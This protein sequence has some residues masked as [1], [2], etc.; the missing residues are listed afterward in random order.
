MK[1]LNKA[2]VRLQGIITNNVADIFFATLSLPML[3][4]RSRFG[5]R[6]SSITA[7]YAVCCY[8]TIDYDTTTFSDIQEAS[9]MKRVTCKF[10]VT[11]WLNISF[12]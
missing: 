6:Q 12:V 2:V 3:Q 7:A 1:I 4:W 11:L 8:S 10:V 9:L 5:S